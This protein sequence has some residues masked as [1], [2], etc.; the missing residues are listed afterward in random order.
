MNAQ[1]K[2]VVT[3]VAIVTILAIGVGGAVIVAAGPHFKGG[4][5]GHFGFMGHHRKMFGPEHVMNFFQKRLELTDEQVEQLRP[6]LEE[7]MKEHRGM[8]GKF[9]EMSPED[10]QAEREKMWQEM[11]QKLAGIL[12]EEQMETARDMHEDMQGMMQGMYQTHSE[13]HQLFEE[14][15]LTTAQKAQFFKIFMSYR[16]DR[17][18]AMTMMM[19]T[20]EEVM[21]MVLNEEFD[22]ANVRETYQQTTAK[23]E[24]FVVTRA[25]MMAD[26][27]EVLTPE[28]LKLL[29]DRL[30]E[31][32]A[33]VQ[34]NMQSRHAMFGKWFSQQ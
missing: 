31:L 18:K 7:Q 9:R 29:Q 5:R 14:L 22:E 17:Q 1:M 28:Q 33:N 8:A 26:M 15:D 27:K 23:F 30:P 3:V 6:I 13:F 19:E 4:R 32:F 21:T 2:K 34:D 24:N 11:E 20:A 10:I 25:K 12:T 16:G